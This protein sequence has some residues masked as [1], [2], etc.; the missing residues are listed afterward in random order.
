MQTPADN[1]GRPDISSAILAAGPEAVARIV[2]QPT[3]EDLAPLAAYA[4]RI[5]VDDL[6]DEQLAAR[7][8]IRPGMAGT[9]REALTGLVR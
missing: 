4:D 7:L 5:R 3:T 8:G 2:G 6:D 1:P 9:A